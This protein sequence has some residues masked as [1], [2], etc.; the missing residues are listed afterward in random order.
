MRPTLRKAKNIKKKK[1][2]VEEIDGIEITPERAEKTT[3]NWYP[4]H[5]VKATRQIKEKL[6]LVDI[7]LEIRDARVPLASGNDFLLEA[8]GNKARLTVLNKVNLADPVVIEKWKKYLDSKGENYIFINGLDNKV[9]K[10]LTALAKKVLEE[11]FKKNGGE[12]ERQDRLRMMM[13]GLP[14]TGKSTIINR[15]AGRSATRTANKPGHTRHQQWIKLDQNVQLL[16]TPGVM[17]P[18]ITNEEQGFWLCCIHAIRDEIV[19]PD[20]ICYFL[21]NFLMD[22]KCQ[23][24]LDKY[25]L[26]SYD[27]FGGDPN[28]CIDQIAQNR[29]FLLPGGLSNLDRAYK[30]ILSDFRDGEFGNI[31]FEEPPE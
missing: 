29:K 19:G 8:V 14:N 10:D 30:T 13:V 12:G 4:G 25:N 9:M 1:K 7:V 21:V 27:D 23:E 31:S 26:G 24:L 16:D 2:V 6:K 3:I 15:L 17:P 5:M 20:D 18:K 11:N 22:R 28:R